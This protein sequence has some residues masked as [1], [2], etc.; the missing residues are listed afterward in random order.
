M[1]YFGISILFLDRLDF[2]DSVS[3]TTFL[4][5]DA[6]NF[7]ASVIGGLSFLSSLLLLQIFLYV[8]SVQ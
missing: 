4:I 5:G 8:F 7:T 2:S 3:F 1:P 6:V